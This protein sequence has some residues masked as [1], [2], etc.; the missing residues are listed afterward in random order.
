MCWGLLFTRPQYITA[1]QGRFSTENDGEKWR[2][3]N[4][5]FAGCVDAATDDA[6]AAVSVVNFLLLRRLVLVFWQQKAPS[7]MTLV[8]R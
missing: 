2:V 1:Q 7:G 3:G 4:G 5:S 8:S 6:A